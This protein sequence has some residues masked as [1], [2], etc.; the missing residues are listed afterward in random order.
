MFIPRNT[1][2]PDN[3]QYYTKSV[4]IRF[5]NL[6]K[7]DLKNIEM[8]CSMALESQFCNTKRH[9]ALL[10]EKGKCVLRS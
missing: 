6:G 1:V 7:F 3:S 10:Y 8:A 2:I 4:S 9:G 5:E